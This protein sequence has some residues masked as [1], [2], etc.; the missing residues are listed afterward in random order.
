MYNIYN[1]HQKVRIWLCQDL[2]EDHT[3]ADLVEDHAVAASAAEAVA[4]AE[5]DTVD[6][7]ADLAIAAVGTALDTTEAADALEDYWEFFCSPS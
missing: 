2:E 3:V 6:T 5:A 1:Q 7:E 4:S